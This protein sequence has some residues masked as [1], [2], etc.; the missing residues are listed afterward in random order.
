MNCSISLPI[1]GLFAGFQ[2]HD[3]YYC[4]NINSCGSDHD[5]T[6]PCPGLKPELLNQPDYGH[7]DSG[8]LWQGHNQDLRYLYL[9]YIQT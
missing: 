1:S 2:P 4:S 3:Q 9:F 6:P 7:R 8:E 5:K